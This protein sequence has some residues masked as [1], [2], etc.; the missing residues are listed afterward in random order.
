MEK[1][2]ENH[3]RLAVRDKNHTMDLVINPHLFNHSSTT[4]VD[5]KSELSCE[6]TCT[7]GKESQKQ[8]K[9]VKR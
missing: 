5:W 9:V 8:W 7:I 1:S 6:E 3:N 2:V 4:L